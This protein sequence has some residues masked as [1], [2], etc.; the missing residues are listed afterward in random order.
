M[1]PSSCYEREVDAADHYAQLARLGLDAFVAAAAPAALVR[2]RRSDT[3][4]PPPPL[5]DDDG[6]TTTEVDAD[7]DGDTMVGMP[8]G[9]R[10]RSGNGAPG[11][12]ASGKT[13]SAPDMITVGRTPNNDVVLRDATVSRLH[14][15]FRQRGASWLVADA[16]SKNGSQLDGLPLEPR[17]ERAIGAGQQV[18]IGDLELTFY[19][20]AELFRVLAP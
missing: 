16:G 10:R 15:F 7:H 18:K 14:A 6:D 5:G 2:R 1:A 9:T 20:A 17:K 12:F 8:D 3:P 13:S 4:T 11:F 19:T